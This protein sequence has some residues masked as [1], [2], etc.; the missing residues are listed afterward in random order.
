MVSFNCRFPHVDD[1]FCSAIPLY[2]CVRVC[3]LPAGGA[4]VRLRIQGLNLALVGTVSWGFPE[5][6]TLMAFGLG[7]RHGMDYHIVTSIKLY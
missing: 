5:G 7:A 3:L 4:L 6:F 2:A 1:L